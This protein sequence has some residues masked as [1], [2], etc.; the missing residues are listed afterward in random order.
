MDKGPTDR[1]VVGQNGRMLADA[2][3]LV[4]AAFVLFVV[5]G[6]AAT[7]LGLAQGW[8]WARN[9]VFRLAHLAAIAF[10]A[11]ESLLGIACPLTV[12]ED[13]LRGRDPGAESFV[14]RAV[15]AALY[16]DLPEAVFTAVYVAFALLVAWTWWR[17]PPRR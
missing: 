4:H 11:A 16:W 7:W 17:W 8:A 3:L 12:W 10:V 13:A 1:R 15:R 6:L 2:I 14:G 5:G 9:R